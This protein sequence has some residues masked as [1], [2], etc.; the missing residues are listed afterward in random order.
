MNLFGILKTSCQESK[1]FS[2][3]FVY[4]TSYRKN[5]MDRTAVIRAYKSPKAKDAH[6]KSFLAVTVGLQIFKLL[7]D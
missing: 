1:A 7:P 5:N 3:A 2:M 6:T 4:R